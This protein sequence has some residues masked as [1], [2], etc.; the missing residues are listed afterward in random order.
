MKEKYILV[1]W[2]DIDFDSH[3]ILSDNEVS[4]CLRED[5]EQGVDKNGLM[6]IKYSCDCDCGFNKSY[7]YNEKEVE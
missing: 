4:S 5:H 6:H 7:S 3:E 1:T 2:N